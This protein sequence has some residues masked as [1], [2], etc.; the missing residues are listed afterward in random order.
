M[1]PAEE[2]ELL[3]WGLAMAK[4]DQCPWEPSCV[5][6]AFA[7]PLATE[8]VLTMQG[9]ID[10]DAI[11]SPILQGKLPEV[12]ADGS[13]VPVRLALLAAMKAF[14]RVPDVE[15]TPENAIAIGHRMIAAVNDAFAMVV[16]MNP[17]SGFDAGAAGPGGLGNWLPVFAALVNLL[18]DESK[19]LAMPVQQAFAILAGTKLN[20][21]WTVAGESYRS[22]EAD[23]FNLHPS[24]FNLS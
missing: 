4:A 16:K 14:D 10:L 6:A 18:H 23:G 17:P 20:A 13:D 12:D 9:W 8:F 5:A 2:Q 21:G 3:Q 24:P 1:T 7:R 15:C 22:R 11:R 19:A